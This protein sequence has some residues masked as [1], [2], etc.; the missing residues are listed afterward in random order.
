MAYRVGVFLSELKRRKVYQV[1]LAYIV[2]G[3]GVLGAAELIMDPLGLEGARPIIVILTLLGF[4]LAM[5][6]AWAYEV[7]P[8]QP[9]MGIYAW[10]S[11][12]PGSV[13]HAIRTPRL[14][15]RCEY[16]STGMAPREVIFG[17]S[18]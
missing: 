1:A 5:V 8:E 16:S 3:L 15:V 9:N 4:P 2:V 13:Q 17:L 12:G 10:G 18:H 7:R 6:L 11:F 14:T